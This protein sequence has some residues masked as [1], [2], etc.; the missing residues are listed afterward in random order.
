MTINILK[1]E[2]RLLAQ[3]QKYKDVVEKSKNKKAKPIKTIS[4]LFDNIL[5]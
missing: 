5:I 4:K 2:Q 3:Q 1:L